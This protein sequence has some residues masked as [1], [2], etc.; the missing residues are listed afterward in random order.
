MWHA[1]KRTQ[2]VSKKRSTYTCS[3]SPHVHRHSQRSEFHSGSRTSFTL[4]P[5]GPTGAKQKK[6]LVVLHFRPVPCR[7]KMASSVPMPA[8]CSLLPTVRVS[9]ACQRMRSTYIICARTCVCSQCVCGVVPGPLEDRMPRRP[10]QS[11][12]LRFQSRMPGQAARVTTAD[13]NLEQL[14]FSESKGSHAPPG[15]RPR[16]SLLAKAALE[17]DIE[18]SRCSSPTLNCNPRP[19][20]ALSQQP[21]RALPPHV[22]A[23]RAVDVPCVPLRSNSSAMAMTTDALL[24]RRLS[25]ATVSAFACT[26]VPVD[27]VVIDCMPR[28]ILNCVLQCACGGTTP[29]KRRPLRP[30]RVRFQSRMP[31]QTTLVNEAS[32]QLSECEPRP[33]VSGLLA[34]AAL[35]GAIKFS[36]R[37]SS[38]S[39]STSMR[40][41]SCLNTS[42]SSMASMETVATSRATVATGREFTW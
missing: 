2:R 41:K 6:N 23:P 39:H 33:Q 7:A 10:L 15:P 31:Q 18:L 21:A 17:G 14:Q 19:R 36:R 25:F 12:V 8:L 13:L 22:H 38:P 24:Q 11:L 5:H 35:E 20:R 40:R 37:R 4:Y 3:C 28:M 9:A 26:S 30:L 29:V 1:H 42:M 27:V 34:K 16:L 32:L